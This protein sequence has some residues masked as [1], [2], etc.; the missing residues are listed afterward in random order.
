MGSGQLS[1][2]YKEVYEEDEELKMIYLFQLWIK[3]PEIRSEYWQHTWGFF[4]VH[5]SV[6]QTVAMATTNCKDN[7]FFTAIFH[8]VASFSRVW[9]R[10]IS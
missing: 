4:F 10:K 9:L 7:H 2:H 5:M 8:L 6:L 1:I 3:A